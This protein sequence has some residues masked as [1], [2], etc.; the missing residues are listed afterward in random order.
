MKP[1]WSATAYKM[2]IIHGRQQQ[3]AMPMIH[4][5]A[6]QKRTKNTSKPRKIIQ[7]LQTKS[8]YRY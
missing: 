8:D 7:S 4:A 1:T 2:A 6:T 5:R 3:T